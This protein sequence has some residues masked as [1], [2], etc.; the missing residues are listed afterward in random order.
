MQAL[1]CRCVEQ[2]LA[3]HVEQGAGGRLRVADLCQVAGPGCTASCLLSTL[4]G[5][6]ASNAGDTVACH[7]CAEF[8][9]G[10][11]VFRARL[12]VSLNVQDSAACHSDAQI[13][14]LPVSL[15]PCVHGVCLAGAAEKGKRPG[16]HASDDKP[17]GAQ[18]QSVLQ[19]FL[20]RSRSTAGAYRHVGQ[21]CRERGGGRAS[22]HAGWAVLG[23]TY[24]DSQPSAPLS[25]AMLT[26]MSGGQ[27][28]REVRH[29]SPVAML[30]GLVFSPR[31]ESHCVFK[32]SQHAHRHVSQGCR[33]VR[34]GGPVASACEEAALDGVAREAGVAS[35]EQHLQAGV[36]FRV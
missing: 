16:L 6:D 28:C 12:Q 3:A 24:S 34:H 30:M 31:S 29:G 33:E 23:T 20:H 35:Q 36:G 2:L 17:A 26:D 32:S 11:T 22:S 5:L 15:R 9:I 21:G 25:K 19:T 14:G 27:G 18:H 13:I 4:L 10:L 8:A 7:P 1:E